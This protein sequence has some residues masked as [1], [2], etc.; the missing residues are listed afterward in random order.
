MSDVT[1]VIGKYKVSFSEYNADDFDGFVTEQHLEK[2]YRMLEFFRQHNIQI[3]GCGC[4]DSSS[5]MFEGEE[6]G[7]VVTKR[8][9][10]NLSLRKGCTDVS[11]VEV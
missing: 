10:F 3:D 11:F 5:V 1:R 9:S 4:C 2:A 6:F 7:S 8:N